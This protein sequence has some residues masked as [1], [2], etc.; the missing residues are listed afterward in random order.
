MK[1][2]TIK[3]NEL[4]AVALAASK[5]QV[6]YYLNGVF[7][8]NDGGMIAT[9]GH[10][11]HTMNANP[12]AKELK[13]F[14]LG[15]ADIKAIVGFCKTHAKTIDKSLQH[16]IV[17]EL[18][19]AAGDISCRIMVEKLELQAYRCNAVDG[20]FPDWR[21]ILPSDNE[22]LT[23][24]CFNAGYMGDFEKAAKL[25][26]DTRHTHIKLEFSGGGA[27][28]K[29]LCHNPAFMGVLMPVRVQL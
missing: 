28:I 25:V 20:N 12:L 6:R 29:V 23:E 24:I 21:R 18:T 19:H 8:E 17:I 14:I 7:F 13:G 15:N 9:D 11:M 1:T 26:T 3:P 10:R 16:L 22:A 2:L 5:K 27:P 4:E